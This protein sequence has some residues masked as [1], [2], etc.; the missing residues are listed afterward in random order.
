M[1]EESFLE[2]LNRVSG[3]I[4]ELKSTQAGL[5][6]AVALEVLDS[7]DFSQAVGQ[8]QSL[9]QWLN[10]TG[11]S[12]PFLSNMGV[13]NPLKFGKSLLMM[14]ILLPRPLVRPAF[15]WGSAPTKEP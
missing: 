15:C 5:T 11:K 13:I 2:T 14:P 4:K 8:M 10:E 12:Y 7:I 9:L 6:D 3:S 1:D